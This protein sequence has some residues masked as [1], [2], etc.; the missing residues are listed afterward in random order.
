MN[1]IVPQ[2]P[3]KRSQHFNETYCNIQ[4]LDCV[5]RCVGA[6]QKRTTSKMLQQKFDYFQTWFNTILNVATCFRPLQNNN[7]KSPK[8]ASSESGNPDGK[9]FNFPLEI[10]STLFTSILQKVRCGAELGDSK[11][12]RPFVK[13]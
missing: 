5:V 13:F 9:K 8:F 12:I 7:V 4:R 6:D 10:E 11:R 3:V 2:G 1:H